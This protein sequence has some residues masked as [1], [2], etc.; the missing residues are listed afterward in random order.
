MPQGLLDGSPGIPFAGPQ[1]APPQAAGPSQQVPMRGQPGMQ[2]SMHKPN[3]LDRILGLYGADPNTHIPQEQ[4]KGALGQGLWNAGM[5]MNA[6][7][8]RGHD[9]PTL[10]QSLGAAFQGLRGTGAQMANEQRQAQMREMLSS[11]ALNPQQLQAAM[12]TMLANGD[13]EG[14]R[15][16]GTVLQQLLA[17]GDD[18]YIKSKDPIYDTLNGTWIY[19]ESGEFAAP[20]EWRTQQHPQT[21]RQVEVPYY[22]STPDWEGAVPKGEADSTIKN[23]YAGNIRY[24]HKGYRDELKRVEPSYRLTRAALSRKDNALAGD[25]AAQLSLLYGFIRALDPNSVVREGEVRLANEAK[26]LR[27]KAIGWYNDL[28]LDQSKI[29]SGEQIDDIIATMENLAESNEKYMGRVR[30]D[31]TDLSREL[32]GAERPSLFRDPTWETGDPLAQAGKQTFTYNERTY[33]KMNNEWTRVNPETG[34]SKLD[35]EIAA[36][37]EGGE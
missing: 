26:T 1:Q 10:G 28:V 13:H 19:P 8:G 5:A 18:R 9:A 31:F 32:L 21:G 12:Q 33:D 36:I 7:Q 3:L 34:T 22:G 25:G 17:A 37:V 16:V 29:V 20:T 2:Q 24:L 6:I 35:D 4:R 11:G 27:E 23:R 30:E 14:A 15:T